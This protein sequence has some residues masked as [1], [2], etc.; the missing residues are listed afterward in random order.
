MKLAMILLSMTLAGAGTVETETEAPY[1]S[2]DLYYLSHIIQAEAGYCSIEMMEGVGSVVLNRVSDDRF[3]DTVKEV[4]EQPGQYSPITN[5]TF[6]NEPTDQVIEV[7]EDLLINGSKFPSD[8]V[9]QANFPQGNGIY[10]T[11]STSYSTM[12]F[13]N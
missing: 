6:W 11:I 3:P 12:Y 1:S 7:A 4:I 5:G 9:W 10:K 13:C 2:D 8:V